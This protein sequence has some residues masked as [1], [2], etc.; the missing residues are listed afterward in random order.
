MVADAARMSIDRD[1]AAA[2]DRRATSGSSRDALP[3]LEPDEYYWVDLE[4]LEVV[5]RSR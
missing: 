2:F 4:G 5:T 3:E 1:V